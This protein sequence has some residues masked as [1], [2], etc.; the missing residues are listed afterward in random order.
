MRI[1]LV[2][3][4]QVAKEYQGKYNGLIDIS[5]S[6]EG[7]NEAKKLGKTL[8]KRGFD[9]V[10]C[11]DLKRAQETLAAFELN[12]PTIYSKEICE[13]SWGKHEG[14]SFAEIEAMGLQYENFEQ[15]VEALDGERYEEYKERIKNYFYSTIKND[16]AKNI[17]VVTH[18]GVIKTL[19]SIVE[20]ISLEEA[21]SIELP[22]AS[23]IKVHLIKE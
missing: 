20:G 22:Y 12:L 6:K 23:E 4:A 15:W 17:L 14:K 7:V 8:Q 2:R 10:Y 5:L 21:F 1:T 11:S 16:D 9:K 18:A 3:H 13:K 19:L